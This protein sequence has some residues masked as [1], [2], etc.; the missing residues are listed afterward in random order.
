MFQSILSNATGTMTITGALICLGVAL[1]LGA[2]LAYAFHFQPDYT[3]SF[4]LTL[5]FLPSVV[6]VLIA[7]VNG[8]LGVGVAVAGTFSLVRFRSMQGTAKEICFL[9]L[10]VAAGVACG[11]GYVTFA[12]LFTIIL[13]ALFTVLSFTRVGEVPATRRELR[14]TIPEALDYTAVFDEV[15]KQY[16]KRV[17]LVRV[18]TINLGSMFELTYNL[19]LKSPSLEKKMLDEVRAR[20]GN[21]TVICGAVPLIDQM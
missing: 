13:A 20:N 16:A 9:F 10:G 4:M 5:I 12:A 19:D 3:Q 8:N 1:V 14:I 11:M 15:F 6:T 2:I 7:M 21:L 18:K 17:T